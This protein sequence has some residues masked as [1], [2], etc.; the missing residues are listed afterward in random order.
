MRMFNVIMSSTDVSVVQVL[1]EGNVIYDGSV[2]YLVN[3]S[4]VWDDV[5]WRSIRHMHLEGERLCIDLKPPV[6]Q[7]ARSILYGLA[8]V[9]LAFLFGW[10][11]QGVWF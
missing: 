4:N 2:G 10:S 3:M 6:S 5:E 1:D 11:M 9:L 7:P 8:F